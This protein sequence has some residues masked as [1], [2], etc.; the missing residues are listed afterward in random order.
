MTQLD[1]TSP[2]PQGL[3]VLGGTS[4]IALAY[5]RK[6]LTE[7]D[8]PLRI[9]LV[10]R[11][12]QRLQQNAD[13]L[14]ARGA[15]D[16]A[17]LIADLTDTTRITGLVEEAEQRLGRIDEA[18]IAYGSLPDQTTVEA[19]INQLSNVFSVNFTSAA[20]W[21]QGLT[22]RMSDQNGGRIV[23]LGSVAGDRGRMSN[24]AYGAAKAGL[25]TFIA[26]AQHRLARDSSL[27]ITLVKP[28]FVDTPM[29]AHIQPKGI[30][31][32][33]PERV[34]SIMYRAARKRKSTVYAPWFWFWIMS[35]IR[36]LPRAVF[37]RTR[38]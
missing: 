18:L 32:A 6:A 36:F 11:D 25:E 37:H 31:W 12:A 24:Y 1:D 7:S 29:T 27:S 2:P 28:G 13:D 4:A 5:A 3:L 15:A 35:I 10:G 9:L 16:C 20:V 8:R 34:A 22:N 23:V 19:D 17:V 30:L 38:L 14:S 21:V 26:G 33:P